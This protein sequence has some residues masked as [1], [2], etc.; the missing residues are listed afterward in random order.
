MKRI[1]AEG[2]EVTD[3]LYKAK[4]SPVTFTAIKDP[5][6]APAWPENEPS[7]SGPA[8]LTASG[9][10]TFEVTFDVASEDYDDYKSVRA[11]TGGQENESVDVIVFYADLDT[12]SGYVAVNQDDDNTNNIPDLSESGIVEGEDDLVAISL[13]VERRHFIRLAFF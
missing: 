6:E 9:S 3:T 11:Y 5:E 8:D 7:W 12:G 13:S 1:E 2:A 10:E 4:G